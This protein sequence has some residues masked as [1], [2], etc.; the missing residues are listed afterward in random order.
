MHGILCESELY[1][2]HGWMAGHSLELFLLIAAM[3]FMI[4]MKLKEDTVWSIKLALNHYLVKEPV[5]R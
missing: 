3:R 2:F 1:A 5:S 4:S